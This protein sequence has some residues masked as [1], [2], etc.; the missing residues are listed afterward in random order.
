[1]SFMERLAEPELMDSPEQVSAYIQADFSLAHNQLLDAFE[2]KF[3]N[4]APEHI[5]DL[6]CGAA[7]ITLRFARLFPQANLLGLDAG[8][9][10]L[11]Q[12]KSAISAETYEK[13]VSLVQAHLP[14][15][16]LRAHKFDAV[17]SNSLLHH[18]NDPE[19][20]WSAISYTAAPGAAIAVMDLMRPDS[21]A[22][23]NELLRRYAAD[24]PPILKED[25][26]HSLRA[27]YR[28]EEVMAQLSVIGLDLSVEAISDRHLL[29][30]GRADAC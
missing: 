24:A 18:L 15:L 12:A 4:Y 13:R 14:C 23:L 26:E 19:D 2:V 30:T 3:P 27:A 21:E 29:V 22:D 6:G 10:M 7:D 28:V 5:L 20:L 25:F 16:A 8:N 9:N 17:V 1:M 11:L